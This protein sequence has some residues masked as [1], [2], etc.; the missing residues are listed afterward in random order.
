M[1][2]YTATDN[3]SHRTRLNTKGDEGKSVVWQVC[4]LA[5]E[6]AILSFT[7]SFQR[8]VIYINFN[9]RMTLYAY[10]HNKYSDV[11]FHRVVRFYPDHI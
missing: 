5:R 2:V 10:I 9:C 4:I 6:M 7:S 8:I 1:H 3:G 11:E